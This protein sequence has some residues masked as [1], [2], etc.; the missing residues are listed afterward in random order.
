MIQH[1][2]IIIREDVA[3]VGDKPNALRAW[4][5]GV[6][7]YGDSFLVWGEHRTRDSRDHTLHVVYEGPLSFAE[8][9]AQLSDVLTEDER[10][11][12]YACISDAQDWSEG[13]ETYSLEQFED[14]Y[15]Q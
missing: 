2:G 5:K 9:R 11:I 15:S 8:V 12:D 3:Q 14:R 6:T 7:C 4:P 13:E 1:H 10:L